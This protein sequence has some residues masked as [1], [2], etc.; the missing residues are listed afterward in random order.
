M[1]SMEVRSQGTG[2]QRRAKKKIWK[3]KHDNQYNAFA[4]ICHSSV[5]KFPSTGIAVSV[6]RKE[7]M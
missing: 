2:R 3:D 6:E 7:P 1:Q 5:G 4:Q